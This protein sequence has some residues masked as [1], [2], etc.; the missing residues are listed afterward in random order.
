LDRTIIIW[1]KSKETN[2]F[3][4]EHK[5]KQH[6]YWVLELVNISNDQDL[7]F[8]SCS[9]DQ[10]LIIWN[11][12]FKSKQIFKHNDSLLCLIFLKETR[13]IIVGSIRDILIFELNNIQKPKQIIQ[14]KEEW[15]R[16]VCQIEESTFA[17][18]HGD[19]SI[20]IYSKSNNN[21]FL[22]KSSI[23]QCNHY[24]NDLIFIKEEQILISSC[25]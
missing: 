24:I 25:K 11:K 7:L 19:G 8:A 23:K 3:E 12:Q 17:S 20:Q 22:L 5:L 10:S 18:G 4:H 2:Q 6:S 9:S 13:E 21:L 16:S 15:V 1:S 14:L